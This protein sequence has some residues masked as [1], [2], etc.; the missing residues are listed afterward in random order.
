MVRQGSQRGF[1]QV[2]AFAF[3]L[4]PSSYPVLTA[5]YLYLSRDD[6]RYQEKKNKTERA[7]RKKEDNVRLR[8]LVDEVLAVDPR[9]KRI[10]AEEKAARLAKKNGGK[11]PPPKLDAAAQKAAEEA[12]KAEEA[13]AAEEAQKTAAADKVR[14]SSLAYHELSRLVG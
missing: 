2:R 10:R 8:E 7:R 12:K 3:R 6:K 4:I 5:P 1:G 11:A 9:I 14:I 13:K